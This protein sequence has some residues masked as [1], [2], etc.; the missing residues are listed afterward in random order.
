[1]RVIQ[2]LIEQKPDRMECAVKGERVL[3][4]EERNNKKC[5]R[6]IQ[7]LM[8]KVL[9]VHTRRDFAISKNL[10]GYLSYL[11][12]RNNRVLYSKWMKTSFSM[13]LIKYYKRVI[14]YDVEIIIFYL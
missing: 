9:H 2:E 3:A 10:G 1:M 12:S 8:L 6:S 4:L 14:L 5:S 11:T 7:A 13:T